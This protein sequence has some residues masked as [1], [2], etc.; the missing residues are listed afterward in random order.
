VEEVAES[1]LC[2]W[3]I[4]THAMWMTMSASALHALSKPSAPSAAGTYANG[5]KIVAQNAAAR[6]PPIALLR[7][8]VGRLD[9][10]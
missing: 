3:P 1:V 8:A 6:T 9:P 2:S 5:R 4:T 7:Q 10:I